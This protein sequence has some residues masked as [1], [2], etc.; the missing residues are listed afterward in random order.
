M[1]NIISIV[2]MASIWMMSCKKDFIEKDPISTISVDAL[3][4]TDKDFQD[5]VIGGIQINSKRTE[6]K[7]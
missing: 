7:P 6:S 5:A 2:A 1:K 4:K 3:Y